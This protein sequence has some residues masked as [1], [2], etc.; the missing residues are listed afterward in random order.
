[1]HTR[2][3]REIAFFVKEIER[4]IILNYSQT[5]TPK[6]NSKNGLQEAGGPYNRGSNDMNK[7][8]WV[9]M[10]LALKAGGH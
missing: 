7:N 1:M 4:N 9:E 6:A 10:L 3:K 2:N 5:C 8:N